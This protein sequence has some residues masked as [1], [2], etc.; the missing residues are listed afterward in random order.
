[1]FVPAQC[2]GDTTD[3]HRALPPQRS[4]SSTL[5]WALQPTPNDATIFLRRFTMVCRIYANASTLIASNR[6]LMHFLFLLHLLHFLQQAQRV[7]HRCY[8]NAVR[9]SVLQIRGESLPTVRNDFVLLSNGLPS[10]SFRL[11]T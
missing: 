1:L 4:P 6:S 11:A 7:S 8:R 9:T 5:R 3:L 2:T 10:R